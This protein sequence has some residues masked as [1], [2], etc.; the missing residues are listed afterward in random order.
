[1]SPMNPSV[2]YTKAQARIQL[3]ILGVLTVA[4]VLCLLLLGVE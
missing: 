1:M 4:S 3:I 2:E